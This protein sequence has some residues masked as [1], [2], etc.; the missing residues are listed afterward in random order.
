MSK[1]VKVFWRIFFGSLGGA[2][3]FLLLCNWGVFGKMPSIEAIQNPTASLSSQ[4]YAQ[5]GSLMGKYFLED[6][7]NVDFKDISTNVINALVATEDER[8]YN[9]SGIDSRAIA[10]A[11]KGMGKDGGASTITMQTAKNL[12]TDNWTTHNFLLRGI[13]KIKESIIAVKLEKNFTKD[14]ILALYLNS[15]EYSEH[16]YGIRNAAKTFYQKEPDRLSLDEAAMLVGMVN[17]PYLYNPRRNPKSAVDRRNIV[18]DQMKRNGYLEQQKCDSLKSLPINM[19]RYKKLDETTGLGPYFRMILSEELKKWCEIHTKVNGEKYNVFEDGLKIYTTINPRMQIYAEEAVA[20]HVSFMQKLLNQQ[21][22]I[23]DGSVWNGYENVVEAGI[24]HSERWAS[25][26]SSGLSDS[27]IRK[28]FDKKVRMK[29][30]A[31]NNRREIDTLMSPYD[32]VKYCKQMLQTA[33]MAMDPIS[34]EVRAWVGGIDFKTFKYDHVNYN[35]KRQV[36]STIKPLLYSLAIEQA[37]LTPTSTVQDQQQFFGSYGKVPNT[38]RTCSGASLSMADAL[39]KSKNCATAYILKQ[40]DPTGN[41]SAKMFVDFLNN[42]CG[43]QTKI[44][45][46]PSIALG[47]CEI[48]MFEMMQAYTMLPG[49][50]F[51]VKPLF[52]NRIEDRNGNILEN[53]NPQRR[54]VI[55]EITSYHVINMMKG[56]VDFGT[57]KSLKSSFNVSGDIAGKTGT[58]NS[59]TDSWFIG[60]TPQ[61][62]AGTWVG[63]D[64]QFIHFNKDDKNGQGGRAALP[65]WGYFYEKVSHDPNIM[66]I[67]AATTFAKPEVQNN[68]TYTDKPI[69]FTT[70]PGEVEE[71]TDE[72]YKKGY[73]V[74][75][76]IKEKTDIPIESVNPYENS[77]EPKTDIP[78]NKEETVPANPKKNEDELP[79]ATPKAVINLLQNPTKNKKPKAVLPSTP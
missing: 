8:F 77:E 9:H 73:D 51:N 2:I 21:Q 24:K 17:A 19:S 29:V 72:V 60:Y 16:V 70:T 39:A 67:D 28:Q 38:S 56:V 64:D 14:E 66:G 68:L 23:K 1:S 61:L 47:A 62:L 59:N 13:Q 37:G 27:E 18:L 41:N 55:S 42:K 26:K 49:R 15:V 31:W 76:P 25:A 46:N 44:K 7:V 40:L 30:F 45:P 58:T 11:I 54:E 22:N 12:F 6:R 32:S 50:G 63:C 65:I 78:S 74:P 20:K 33:F 5:D 79:S 75:L 71:E 4:V 35:T 10:R 3:L 36:G 34:G 52:I 53:F 69:G 48:S 43:L 57:A